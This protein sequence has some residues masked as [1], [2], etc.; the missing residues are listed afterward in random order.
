MKLASTSSSSS[1]PSPTS[2][3]DNHCCSD[4]V[5]ACF[6]CVNIADIAVEQDASAQAEAVSVPRRLSNRRKKYLRK[7]NKTIMIMPHFRGSRR[8]LAEEDECDSAP[9]AAA[10]LQ[11]TLHKTSAS[12]ARAAPL[13]AAQLQKTLDKTSASP[14]RDD[15]PAWMDDRK[16]EF[17]LT[18]RYKK[19]QEV[20]DTTTM[21]ITQQRSLLKQIKQLKSRARAFHL[22]ALKTQAQW[23]VDQQQ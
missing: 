3:T 2:T 19:L 6:F 14:A 16:I 12:P 15:F 22:E 8:F 21:P 5:C 11:K 7:K 18:T 10:Q 13:A 4:E 17:Q 1:S 20:L 23:A 9:L